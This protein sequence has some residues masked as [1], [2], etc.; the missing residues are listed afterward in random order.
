M[1]LLGFDPRPLALGLKEDKT[2]AF[3]SVSLNTPTSHRTLCFDIRDNFGDAKYVIKGIELTPNKF[4][5]VDAL[6]NTNYVH[7]IRFGSIR[8]AGEAGQESISAASAD[9]G[10]FTELAKTNHQIL[11]DFNGP[12]WQPITVINTGKKMVEGD[13]VWINNEWTYLSFAQFAVID[14]RRFPYTHFRIEDISFDS[15]KSRRN[16]NCKIRKL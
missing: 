16:R 3:K 12:I 13:S 6:A 5:G 14:I 10:G 9:I 2:N 8:S 4:I 7:K 15:A 1:K 11:F